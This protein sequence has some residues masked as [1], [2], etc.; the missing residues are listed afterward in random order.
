MSTISYTYAVNDIQ[1]VL[2]Q[3]FP[4]AQIR[5][6]SVL[7]W[8]RTSENIIMQRHLKVEMTG[9]YLVNFYGVNGISIQTDTIKKWITLPTGIFDLLYDK[10]I[11]FI[12]FNETSVVPFEKNTRFQVID[13]DDVSRLYMTP[14]NSPSS[15]NPFA[16]R[17]GNLIY[18]L[19]IDDE[20]IA[21]VALSLFSSLDARPD[22]VPMTN[23]LGIND[24]Q[25]M[26]MKEMVLTLGRFALL[27]PRERIMDG[28]D[29]KTQEDGT[30][31]FAK[32]TKTQPQPQEQQ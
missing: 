30:E 31:Q 2:Q 29:D 6:L 12:S 32:N 24:E 26:A 20:N 17:V 23:T 15:K 1:T 11:N 16:Y 28:G 19:G 7:F 27:V 13:A 3:T 21:S 14:Y 5:P 18:L 4:D 10:G 25:Y 22:Y 9:S 8:I